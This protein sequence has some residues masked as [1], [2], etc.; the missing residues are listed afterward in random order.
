[1]VDAFQIFLLDAKSRRLSVETV[2]FYEQRLGW[3]F[4]WLNHRGVTHLQDVDRNE[5]R[6]YLAS[7]AERDL[8]SYTQH[9]AARAI[10]TF[11]RFCVDEGWIE[12]SPMKGVRMPRLDKTLLPAF[13]PEDVQKLLKAAQYE[14]D[15][16][17]ILCLLDT[18]CRATEFLNWRGA[19]LDT[20]QGTVKVVG[21][22][23]KERMVYLGAKALKA[24]LRYFIERGHPQPQ[25]HVWLSVRDNGQP[26][27]YSGLRLM[28]MRLGEMAGV[29]DVA[30]HRFRRTFAL[31]SLRA[32]MS[33]YELQRLMGHA[34][35]QVLR[36]YLALSESDLA[37]AH[38]R[39]GAVDTM[40]GDD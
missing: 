5:I 9:A 25:E 35:I 21:K 33:V 29:D 18:G 20:K 17:I 11:S 32:G 28:L 12:A 24:L 4:A 27:A 34:D 22:G 36:R 13:E 38:K 14:R 19:D 8:S 26:I 6:A 15:R 3:F 7:L 16:A 40:L 2:R 31:W 10:K 23:R 30:P 39:F 1:M 37:T